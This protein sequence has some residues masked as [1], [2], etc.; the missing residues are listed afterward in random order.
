M[1]RGLLG[2]NIIII[3]VVVSLL[4]CYTS[5]LSGCNLIVYM[6]FPSQLKF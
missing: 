4:R 2:S 5:M 6:L 1:G 3:T